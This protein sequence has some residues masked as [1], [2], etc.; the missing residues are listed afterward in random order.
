MSKPKAVLFDAGGTLVTMDP[1]LFGDV[2][3]PIVGERPEPVHMLEAHYQAMAAIGENLQLLEEGPAVWWPWW[4]SQFMQLSGVT[5][6]P[7][8]VAQLAN[9]H[10]LWRLALPGAHDGVTAVVAAGYQVAVVSNADGHVK[11]DLGAAG[12][13]DLFEVIID[14]TVVGVSKPDPAIFEYALAALGVEASEAWYVGDSPLFDLGGAEAAGLSEFVLVDPFDLHASYAPR[15]KGL[16]E[17]VG[18]LSGG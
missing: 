13:G 18:L 15:V 14:S 12:F 2:V 7:D 16:T 4:L 9:G 17:L 11:D 10:G 5:P 1:Q 8:A 3:E 6:H